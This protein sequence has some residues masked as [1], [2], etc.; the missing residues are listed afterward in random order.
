MRKVYHKILQVSGNV[1]SVEAE[2]VAYNDLAEVSTK[3][4]VSLASASMLVLWI[5]DSA[6]DLA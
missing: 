4:G 5:I 3:R 1:I 6:L 2:G